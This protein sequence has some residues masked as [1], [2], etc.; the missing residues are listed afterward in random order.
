MTSINFSSREI[1]EDMRMTARYPLVCSS[2]DADKF[3]G[4]AGVTLVTRSGP[5]QGSTVHWTFS[6]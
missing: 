5:Y 6:I 3:L 4:Q 1:H 2:I